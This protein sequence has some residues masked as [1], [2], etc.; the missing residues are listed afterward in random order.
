[1][2]MRPSSAR[3]MGK[4]HNENPQ[5]KYIQTAGGSRTG[6]PSY[7]SGTCDVCRSGDNAVIYDASL[8]I[9][10]RRIWAMA[11]QACFEDHHGRLGTGLGQKYEAAP[12]AE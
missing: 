9:G 7:Y 3:P 11:C 4:I 2:N 8:H 10:N 12:E 5:M 1:M 6:K